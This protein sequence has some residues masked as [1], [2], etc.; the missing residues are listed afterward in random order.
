MNIDPKIVA[1]VGLCLGIAFPVGM[2][3]WVIRQERK[4]K[5]RYY[6]DPFA[7]VKIGIIEKEL[8]EPKIDDFSHRNVSISPGPDHKHTG[9]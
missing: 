2:F 4:V 7:N 5:P 8:E 3:I 6:E 1:I 9:I